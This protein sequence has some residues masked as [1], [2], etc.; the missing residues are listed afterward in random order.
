MTAGLLD[1]LDPRH[2]EAVARLILPDPI[3]GWVAS[4]LGEPSD[5]EAAFARW[6]LLPR[7]L[8]GTP[9]PQPSTKLLGVE[10]AAPIGVAPIGLMAALH[11]DGEVAAATATARSGSVFVVSVNATT[12]IED[13]AAAAP[14]AHL[15]FQLYNW[16]D[17]GAL[18]EVVSRAERAGC[19]AIVPLVNTPLPVAHVPAAAGFRLPAGLELAHGAAGHGLET[20]LDDDYIA[21]LASITQ[22]PIVAKGVMHPD[23]ARR[24]L[25]AGASAV[26]ISNHGGRQLPRSVATLDALPAIAEAVG[27]DAEIYLDG[28]ARSGTD[29]LIALALGARAVFMGRPSCWALAVGGAAGLERALV[30]FRDEL[31]EAATLCG[32]GNLAAVPSDVVVRPERPT[33]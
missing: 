29:V 9:P 25:A 19:R 20:G 1:R 16:S 3:V 18:S 31:I 30:S 24:M 4:G 23:D 17:R 14:D 32:V 7:A 11:P 15:W 5:N 26:W 12:S 33:D 13:I 2:Y 22:L 21:W 28:G 27:D 6:R 10:A 8:S